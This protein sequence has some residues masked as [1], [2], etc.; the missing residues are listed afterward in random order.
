MKIRRLEINGFKS[1]VDRS[2]LEFPEGVTAVVG[3]NGCGKSNVVDAIRWVM[4]EQS[5]KNLRGRQM[6]D[7]IFGGSESRKPLGMA[8]VSLVFSTEDGRV[9][10]KYLNFAEIQITRRLYRD[11]ESEYLINKTPCRLMDIS[12]LF[13][14]T[15][16]GARAYS[17]IEQGRIGM[18]L[19]AKPEERRFLIE[20]A[21]GVTKYKSRKQLA[22]KK[23]DVTRQNLMRIGD[24]VSEIKRQLNSLQ[25]Q[26]KKAEK[27]L[28]LREE[29]KEIDLYFFKKRSARIDDT[30][31]ALV[32]ECERLKNLESVAVAEIGV[33][34]VQLEDQRL[35]VAEAEGRLDLLQQEAYRHRT[36]IQE[37]EHR[38]AL[39]RQEI[40][41]LERQR[42]R[43]TEELNSFEHKLSESDAER[44]ALEATT[45]LFQDESSSEELRLRECEDA[46][47]VANGND[48]RISDEL[49]ERRR[50]LIRTVGAISQV[51]SQQA[52]AHK[53][54]DVLRERNDRNERELATMHDQLQAADVRRVE[55]ERLVASSRDER[56]ALQ[57]SIGTIRSAASESKEHLDLS[58]SRVQQHKDEVGKVSSRLVSLQELDAQMAGCGDGVKA[59]LHAKLVGGRFTRLVADGIEV[60][61]GFETAISAVLGERLQAVLAESAADVIEAAAFLRREGAGRCGFLLP[62]NPSDEHAVVAGAESLRSK[63]QYS[64]EHAARVEPVLSRAFVVATLGEAITLGQSNPHAVFVTPDGDLVHSGGFVE[65]GF[66]ESANHGLIQ[67]KREIRELSAEMDRL[68]SRG[69]MLVAER[70]RC[71]QV[72]VSI[73]ESLQQGVAQLHRLEMTQLSFDKD[74]QRVVSETARL[75]EVIAARRFEC[76]QVREEQA[77]LAAEAVRESQRQGEL[78]EQKGALELE[79]SRL[80]EQQEASRALLQQAREDLTAVKVRN[81]A[82]REKRESA[83]RSLQRVDTEHALFVGKIGS[84]RGELVK[85]DAR[86]AELGA[87]V[88]DSSMELQGLLAGSAM[89]DASLAAARADLDVGGSALRESE[90]AIDERRRGLD[91]LRSQ[92]AAANLALSGNL[93]ER[94]HLEVSLREKYRMD[95]SALVSDPL[96][97]PIDEDAHLA[98]QRDLQQQLDEL[99]E[100]NLTAIEEY[101]ELEQRHTFLSEQ[102]ADL[103]D[104]LKS[105]HQAIQR[106]N[107]TTRQRF[108]ETFQHVNAR[109]QEVFPRLFCGGKAELRLTNEEDLLETGLDIVVQPPGKKLQ[110]VSLLS[111]GEKALTAV[112]LIF[113]I[114]LIKPSPFCLLD[115]VDAPLDDANIGRFNDIIREMAAA[116][117]FILIT[118]SKTTMAVADTLY[119]VTMEEPGVSKLVS[120]KLQ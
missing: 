2:V 50:S 82:N 26:V 104:S 106:I 7:I 30:R 115:E 108:L 90:K 59:V 72:F 118:H 80:Q 13:M 87:A 94:D 113:S 64:A 66:T 43:L 65:T 78:G 25:R 34:Q 23:I 55:L 62:Q 69:E 27:F 89:H 39:Q 24:I 56:D 117:Q 102:K 22:L 95:L 41:G 33:H 9:P 84:H 44:S 12:E 111:G 8:E 53:R 110:N 5:A 19:M 10:A 120:V 77:Q 114:F 71:R 4:G 96:D 91:V 116:S 42:Q 20:D 86:L 97:A 28:R 36:A 31:A 99:G 85:M 107:R 60:V 76:E 32:I 16:I 74:L 11:G 105:L 51:M 38:L 67:M 17:I 52:S 101:G 6:E 119:G 48:Q 18:I 46:L 98:R 63:V 35:R 3:P 103:E 61:D 79:I 88:A 109:F 57:K 83:V 15:G 92:L 93:M 73:E 47:E 14:D 29:L 112:A 49:D 81:A 70:D 54:S 1:F 75:S 45:F 68:E 37:S 21:A 100:V 58:E 40:E